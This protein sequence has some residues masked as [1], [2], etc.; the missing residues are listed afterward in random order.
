MTNTV[1]NKAL[2]WTNLTFGAV[3]LWGGRDV[4]DALQ[5][6]LSEY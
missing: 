4:S 3:Q 2:E 1:P 6:K 5:A